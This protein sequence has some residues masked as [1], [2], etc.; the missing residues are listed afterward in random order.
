VSRF[1]LKKLLTVTARR[2][3]HDATSCNGMAGE[4]EENE[5]INLKVHHS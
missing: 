5:K 3:K 2:V 4:V 1:D